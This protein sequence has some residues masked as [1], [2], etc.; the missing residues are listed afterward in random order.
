M[1]TNAPIPDIASDTESSGRRIRTFAGDMKIVKG[2]GMP[3]LVPFI[4][5]RTDTANIAASEQQSKPIVAQSIEIPRPS[6]PVSAPIPPPDPENLPE[7]K[8]IQPVQYPDAQKAQAIKRPAAFIETYA[9]DFTDK[10]KTEKASVATVLAAEQDSLP[11]AP[12]VKSDTPS[13]WNYFYI[14]SGVVLLVVGSIG[15]YIA[16]TRY[17]AN[18]LP[19][20]IAPKALVP[21]FVD[22][23]EQIA[24]DGPALEQAIIKSVTRPLTQGNARLL[25][26]ANSSGASIFSR[27]SFVP[28]VLVRNIRTEGSVAGVVSVDGVQS[29]FF[30][31]AV[32]SYG[33]SFSGMLSWETVM[34]HTLD[35]FFPPY[36]SPQDT[37]Q[38]SATS[39]MQVGTTT[40]A[41]IATTSDTSTSSLGFRDEVVS[42]HDVRVY[43]D[44]AGKSVVMYG[45]WDRSTLVIARDPK[46][47]AEII[48]RIAH[49]RTQ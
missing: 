18:T 13:T 36:T 11:G 10:V 1:E 35:G 3:D 34:P 5:F 22:E 49:A 27:L 43:R 26:D 7:T 29:P 17:I 24:G 6:A 30:V 16:Y 48:Q 31:L 9:G 19:I 32:T 14:I 2:G 8:D 33:N 20:V 21:L 41:I 38:R 47:F 25:S 12:E 23:Q 44:A 15:V 39:S 40:K 28:D 46:A 4:P 42:N 45:Y 37:A